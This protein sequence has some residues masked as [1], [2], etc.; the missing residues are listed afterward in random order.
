ME[1]P[2]TDFF[3]ADGSAF[4]TFLGSYNTF[5]SPICGVSLQ[6]RIRTY[7]LLTYVLQIIIID[8]FFVKRGNIHTPSLF[9]PAPGNLYYYRKGWNLKALGS[10]VCA[11]LFGIPG[12]VGAY[13]PGSVS[14]GATHIYQMGWIVCFAV[15]STFYFV[16]SRILSPQVVPKG[17]DADAKQ[18]E[19]F[20]NTEGYL[21]GDSLVQFRG[22][23]VLYGGEQGSNSTRTGSDLIV[24]NIHE[25]V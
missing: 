13:H 5:I 14:K 21:E 22:Q 7:F 19:G 16:I 18:F 4:L 25:K 2:F 11:A 3:A 15:A 9:N 17:Y 23:E 10:W 24:N 12:L 1:N 6:I 20:A 8:Y